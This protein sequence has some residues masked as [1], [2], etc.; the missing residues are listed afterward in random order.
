MNAKELNKIN[1]ELFVYIVMSTMQDF[2][3]D[4]IESFNIMMKKLEKELSYENFEKTLD[5]CL[6]KAS[7]YESLPIIKSILNNY[8]INNYLKDDFFLFKNALI[9][10]NYDI[11]HFLIEKDY[12][13]CFTHYIPIRFSVNLDTKEKIDNIF[14]A[15]YEK[16]ILNSCVKKEKMPKIDIIKI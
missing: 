7:H 16:K 8:D 5:N 1:E 13:N 12:E 14:N 4:S 9:L 6:E 2:S 3:M 11:V 15:V 10:L